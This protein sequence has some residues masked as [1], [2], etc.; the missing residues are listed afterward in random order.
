MRTIVTVAALV[1]CV[2][3]CAAVRAA[4]PTQ[5]IEKVGQLPELNSSANAPVGGT[6]FSQYRYWSKPGYRLQ[7]PLSTRIGVMRGSIQTE[8]GDF[9]APAVAGGVVAYCT[10]KLAVIDP[11]FGPITKACFL[12]KSGSGSFDTVRAAPGLVWFEKTLDSRIRYEQGELQVPRQDSKK[13]EL[14]YQG[15]SAKTLRLT[16]REYMND[17]ARPVFFQDVSYEITEFPMEVT[18]RTVRISVLSADNNGIR[19][20]VLSGF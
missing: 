7:A 12:D 20:K 6:M 2:T 17:F 5:V 13:H 8:L 18:F 16:Y 14:L 10:E 15:A 3:G 9:V 1:I 4:Q 11:P 19:Y